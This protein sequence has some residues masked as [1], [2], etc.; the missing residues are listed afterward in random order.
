[1]GMLAWLRRLMRA[2]AGAHREVQG[3]RAAE[4]KAREGMRGRSNERQEGEEATDA[5]E[6]RFWESREPRRAW[7]HIRIQYRDG[8]GRESERDITVRCIDASGRAGL[9][10]A[11]CHLRGET[12]SFRLDRVKSAC[13]RDGVVI[14]DLYEYLMDRA[15]DIAGYLGIN[16]KLLAP[17]TKLS[18]EHIDALRVLLYVGRADGSLRKREKEIIEEWISGLGAAFPKMD[19]LVGALM[20]EIGRPADRAFEAAVV[21]LSTASQELRWR[22]LALAQAIVSTQ[23]TIA[24]AEGAALDLMRR[25][26]VICPSERVGLAPS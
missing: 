10:L 15:S 25:S 20:N 8:A 21:R 17:L 12:R 22:V 14:E 3:R 13:D 2:F 7:A 23:K 18:D 16:E 4:E 9:L 1:M 26:W 19:D 24:A 11:H 6:G 5:W